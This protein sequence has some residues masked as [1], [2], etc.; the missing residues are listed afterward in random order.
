[1]KI[2]PL[3]AYKLVEADQCLILCPMGA[4][5][6]LKHVELVAGDA[7]HV[8]EYMQHYL[9]ARSAG[10]RIKQ[11]HAEALIGARVVG[12]NGLDAVTDEMLRIEQ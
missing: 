11:A 1:M 10:R 9:H 5:L 6:N 7:N 8:A 2:N 4:K 3:E 12:P